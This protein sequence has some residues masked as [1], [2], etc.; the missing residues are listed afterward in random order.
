MFGT[1]VVYI[2]D[3]IMFIQF[4]EETKICLGLVSIGI[5]Q[6]LI[7]GWFICFWFFF[8]MAKSMMLD[9]L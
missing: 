1:D 5:A 2:F 6:G 9:I 7:F 4:W 8:F 3:I